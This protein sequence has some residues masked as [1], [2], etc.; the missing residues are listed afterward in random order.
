MAITK[1]DVQNAI[2]ELQDSNINASVINIRKLIGG[3]NSTITKYRNEILLE[4][5]ANTKKNIMHLDNKETEKVS[6]LIAELLTD[7]VNINRMRD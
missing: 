2:T 3:S 6:R 7:R 4:Q 5:S 1:Q